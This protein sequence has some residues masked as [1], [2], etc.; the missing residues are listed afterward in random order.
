M[1][2]FNIKAFW[3]QVMD[4]LKEI[5]YVFIEL[6]IRTTVFNTNGEEFPFEIIQFVLFF[7]TEFYIH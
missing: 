3:Q 5:V 6:N 2:H 7:L 1:P 4:L